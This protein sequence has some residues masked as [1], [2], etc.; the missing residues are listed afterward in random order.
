[1]QEPDVSPILVE[2]SRLQVS[3]D[4]DIILQDVNLQLRKGELLY[5]VGRVGSG[6]TS[7][8][9]T[10]IGEFPVKKGRARVA[11]FDLAQL[12][13]RQVPYL[14][15]KMGVIFQDFKLLMDRTAGEN[16]EFVLRATGWKD[17]KEIDGRIDEVLS[18][19]GMQMKKHRMPH[20]LSGGEQQRVAIARALL[21]RPELILA[22][23]PTGNLDADTQ[24]EIMS[25][26]MEIRENRQ[27]A[28]LM[29][30]HNP[31]LL[32]KYPGRIMR[33]EN[34]LLREIDTQQEIDFSDFMGF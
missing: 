17:N 7:L 33:A 20:R 18:K 2:L 21:N 22:D 15:R 16:L 26:F 28:V 34:G 5:L 23:E 3:K 9:R 24:D 13:P 29:V 8:I 11:G 14:R 12:K 32:Q 6:K 4:S 25:L 27:P 31:R 30:T 1:M 19:V 10:L